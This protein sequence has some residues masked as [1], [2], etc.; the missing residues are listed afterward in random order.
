[1]AKP[2]TR[3]EKGLAGHRRPQGWMKRFVEALKDV[4][5]ADCDQRFHYS[6]MDFD[7]VCGEKLWGIGQMGTRSI[8]AQMIEL[9]KC[10]VVC[11]NCHRVRTWK[12]KQESTPD[13][14]TH[15]ADFGET[16]D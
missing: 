4:P 16:S 5:C 1:M 14:T 6:A 3:R 7:H 2:A 12:A 13:N 11:A 8:A 10:N 15:Y 9:A